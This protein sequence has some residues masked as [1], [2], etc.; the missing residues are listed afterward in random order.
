L[1]RIEDGVFALARQLTS[2]WISENV[3]FV[4]HFAFYGCDGLTIQ[5]EGSSIPTTWTPSWN[6]ANRPIEFDVDPII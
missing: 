4:G 2:V 3:E 5:Y 1:E 6:P